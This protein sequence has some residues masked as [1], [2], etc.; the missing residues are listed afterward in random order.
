MRFVQLLLE[1]CEMKANLGLPGSLSGIM[2][3]MW[4]LI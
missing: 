4:S 3:V 2:E 1:P